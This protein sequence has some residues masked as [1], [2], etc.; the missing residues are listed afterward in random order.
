[1]IPFH[2][3]SAGNPS[4]MTITEIVNVSGSVG[5]FVWL[6]SISFRSAKNL[7]QRNIQMKVLKSFNYSALIL[8][9][10]YV[11]VFFVLAEIDPWVLSSE[12]EI[13]AG[14][15][16]TYNRILYPAIAVLIISL[17]LMY[18]NMLKLL[19][20]A[21]TGKEQHFKDYYKTFLLLFLIPWV[22]VWFVHDRAK[23]FKN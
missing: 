7:S 13:E 5:I 8:A 3:Y 20:S 14:T 17:A 12:E 19:T 21:E 23:T 22:G 18:R 11:F 15:P 9:I 6:Y 4:S 16:Y 10:T 1:M 2:W